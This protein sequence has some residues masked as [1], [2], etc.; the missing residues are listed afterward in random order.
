M[1]TLTD[2]SPRNT[3]LMKS[4]I[5]TLVAVAAMVVFSIAQQAVGQ[6]GQISSTATGRA[7]AVSQRQNDITFSNYKF[8]DGE[9]LTQ[10]RIHYATL[11]DPH[12][13]AEG[14]VDNAILLLHWTN[15]GSQALLVPEY[16]D[17]LFATGAPLDMT[18]FFVII[19]DNVGHGRSSKSSDGLKASF[20]RYGYGDMVDIQHKLN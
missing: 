20:P 8:R 5:P 15:A 19:P 1:A 18:R 6:S 4:K 2:H 14:M 13:N 11:G 16:Q 10:L 7:G 12:K 9:T 3:I 17:A